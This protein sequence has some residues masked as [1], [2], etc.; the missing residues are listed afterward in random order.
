[1]AETKEKNGEHPF[2]DSGQLILLIVFLVIWVLDSFFLQKTTILPHAIPLHFR[3][4]VAIV[5]LIAAILLIRAGHVVAGHEQ[6][7]ESLVTGGAFWY[8]RHPLYLGCIL[9][10]LSLV[11]AT[12][13]ILAFLVFLLIVLFY[14]HIASYEEKLL[15]IKF[16]ESY[17]NYKEAT[18]KWLPRFGRTQQTP[19]R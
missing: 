10:Y 14:N 13:S 8:V 4:I 16:G 17:R 9:F 19:D 6:R 1:M 5:T 7:P 3:L 18:G 2:G 15:E 12:L 11:I